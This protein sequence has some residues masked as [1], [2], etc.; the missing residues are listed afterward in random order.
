MLFSEWGSISLDFFD[1]K[2]G[3]FSMGKMMEAGYNLIWGNWN[4]FDVLLFYCLLGTNMHFITQFIPI[5]RSFFVNHLVTIYYLSEKNYNYRHYLDS[6]SSFLSSCLFPMF[7]KSY[8]I[9]GI[10]FFRFIRLS[11][12]IIVPQKIEG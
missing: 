12:V 5:S 1:N 11:K 10:V 2:Y 9:Y 7:E 6:F 8:V 3:L 4:Q